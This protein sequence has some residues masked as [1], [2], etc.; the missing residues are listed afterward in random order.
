MKG[1][2][3]LFGMLFVSIFLL[4]GCNNHTIQED[5]MACGRIGLGYSTSTSHDIVYCLNISTLSVVPIDY[6]YLDY[7]DGK[8]IINP[9]MIINNYYSCTNCTNKCG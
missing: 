8:R 1:Y 6:H 5:I 2:V 9:N 7:G 4:T 3:F